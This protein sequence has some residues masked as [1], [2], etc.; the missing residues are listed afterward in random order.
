MLLM[1]YITAHCP[2]MRYLGSG[3]EQVST[4]QAQMERIHGLHGDL[5]R[6]VGR[7]RKWEAIDA[8]C[9][10]ISDAVS[11]TACDP[12]VCLPLFRGKYEISAIALL[13]ISCGHYDLVA[14][15][16]RGC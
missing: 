3:S 16:M 12:I 13:D 9:F 4:L 14:Y 6:R 11:D 8:V 2:S 15:G 10:P 7:G 1:E 5:T